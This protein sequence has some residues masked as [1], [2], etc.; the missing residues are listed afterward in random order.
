[1]E[2]DV[3]PAHHEDLSPWIAE[4]EDR[5]ALAHCARDRGLDQPVELPVADW[6]DAERH[7]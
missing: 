1:L 6:L 4:P 7:L 2:A 5:L 3:P